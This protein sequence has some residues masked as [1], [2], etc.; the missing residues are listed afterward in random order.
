MSL[1]RDWLVTGYDRPPE[2]A[3]AIDTAFAWASSPQTVVSHYYMDGD[4]DYLFILPD[5]LPDH[6]S[7]T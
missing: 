7:Q 4:P 5:Q 2:V 1:A 3:A 6:V